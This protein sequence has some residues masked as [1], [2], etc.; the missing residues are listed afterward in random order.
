MIKK[1]SLLILISALLIS[2]GKK[3]CPKYKGSENEKCD[4]L[5]KTK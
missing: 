2:C 5:F 1:I 3:N 4:P